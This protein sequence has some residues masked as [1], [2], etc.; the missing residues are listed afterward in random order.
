M[1]PRAVGQGRGRAVP[2]GTFPTTSTAQCCFHLYWD[3]SGPRHR[4]HGKATSTCDVAELL[5][6][7]CP[8]HTGRGEARGSSSGGGVLGRG[9]RFP[10]FTERTQARQRVVKHSPNKQSQKGSFL[11]KK[12]KKGLKNNQADAETRVYFAALTDTTKSKQT[13]LEIK[14]KWERG[15]NRAGSRPQPFSARG[16]VLGGGRAQPRTLLAPCW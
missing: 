12:K 15:P 2:P 11:E 16:R 6:A 4:Y 13:K 1:S 9:G 14:P 3:T 8:L 10:C 5:H 7:W